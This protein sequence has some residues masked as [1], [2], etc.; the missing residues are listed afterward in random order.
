MFVKHSSPNPYYHNSNL[1]SMLYSSKQDMG[2]Q[3]KR[4]LYRSK[5]A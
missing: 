4:R 1:S 3:L 5:D 2:Q